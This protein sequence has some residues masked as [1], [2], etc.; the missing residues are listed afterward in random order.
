MY[1]DR[2]QRYAL[3]RGWRYDPQRM[4]IEHLTVRQ[5]RRALKKENQALRRMGWTFGRE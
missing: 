4:S 5:R 1:D 3:Q 2:C